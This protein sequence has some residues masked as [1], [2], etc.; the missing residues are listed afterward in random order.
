MKKSIDRHP[1]IE[2]CLQVAEASIRIFDTLLQYCSFMRMC[3]RVFLRCLLHPRK[4]RWKQVFYYMDSCGSDATPIISLLGFLIGVILAFQALIQLGRFGVQSYVVNL[5]GSVI[6][7]ELAPLVT[8]VVLA[9]R[10]GS[11]FAAEL[12]SM[13]NDEEL[14]ALLT[15][16]IDTGEYLLFPKLLAMVLVLPC[17]TI[18]SDICGIAGGMAIVCSMLEVSISEYVAKCVEIVHV[19][20]LLQ[21]VI[22]SCFFGVIVSTIGCMKGINSDRNAQ[23]VGDATTSAVVAAIFLIVVVDAV[24]TAFFGITCSV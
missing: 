24:I 11:S 4:I 3:G 21:G 6:V 13:K 7:T 16:G 19:V 14:D 15:M 9:G 5:V 22:K 20:D 2:V 12:S 17:L 10:T 8:A 1:Y 23:G 18:I